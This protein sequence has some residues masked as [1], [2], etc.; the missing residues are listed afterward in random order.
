MKGKPVNLAAAALLIACAIGAFLWWLIHIPS[1]LPQ[2]P[3]VAETPADAAVE[4]SARTSIEP[5][6]AARSEVSA[7]V[8]APDPAR[9]I[10]EELALPFLY[11][12][13]VR[14]LDE[15]G[16]PVPNASLRLAPVRSSLNQAASVSEVHGWTTILWFG[17][18]AEMDVDVQLGPQTS[19]FGSRRV[20]LSAGIPAELALLGN[21][22]Q[23]ATGALR[24]TRSPHPHARFGDRFVSSR[25]PD[26]ITEAA[27]KQQIRRQMDFRG[28]DDPERFKEQKEQQSVERFQAV[29]KRLFV[30]AAPE[31][32]ASHVTVIV[33][34]ERGRPA[35][36]CLVALGRGVDGTEL[37]R[38]TDKQGE[39]VFDSVQ[40]GWW[41]AR[42]GG[43]SAGLARERLF[44]QAGNPMRWDA[45]LDRASR[46]AGHV[47][48]AKGRPAKGK[49]VRYESIPNAVARAS[50]VRVSFED[51][52]KEL[53][54]ESAESLLPALDALRAPWVDSATVDQDGSFELA[55]LPAGLGRLLV[56]SAEN[57]DGPALYVEESLLPRVHD[58]ELRLP[59]SMGS[60]RVQIV[61]PELW[62]SESVELRAISE[63]TGRG[64]SFARE[65]DR[66][67]CAGLI[68][69]W[70]RVEAGAGVLGWHDLGRHF[71]DS[72]A[73]VEI[74]VFAPPAPA[75]VRVL[76][77]V[78]LKEGERGLGLTFYLRR[79]DIDIRGEPDN[80]KGNE[81]LHL[82]AGEYWAF[83]TAL[84]GTMRHRALTLE[85]GGSA[86][87]DLREA[88]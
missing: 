33:L 39:S 80:L 42:A 64:H 75:A 57:S 82:P 4:A 20:H 46:L 10:D 3:V 31:P 59:A 35:P 49:L 27:R 74:G 26:P 1:V 19:L 87:L 73:D 23:A 24:M 25:V 38:V 77:P 7:P 34:D 85:A 15:N 71:V 2:E 44:I 32:G 72:G 22:A 68:T 47:F 70:Y 28:E 54:S 76:L 55:N 18:Q 83:W 14:T 79:P 78:K 41:E 50:H 43:G 40:P 62:Q 29:P 9:L 86:E 84:D 37:S 12:L 56:L 67:R 48:D 8:H 61:L 16:L 53:I 81:P 65:G 13:A 6:Q 21:G 5:T 63:T 45:Q 66:C 11:V 69:G 52:E 30:S 60:L 88:R 58:L 51:G 36:N 17:K